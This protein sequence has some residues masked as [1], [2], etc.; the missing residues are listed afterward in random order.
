[1]VAPFL[2]IATLRP[3]TEYIEERRMMI[4]AKGV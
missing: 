4:V 1:V 2:E 3:P